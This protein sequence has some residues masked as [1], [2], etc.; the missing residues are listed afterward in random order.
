MAGL[1]VSRLPHVVVLCL[2]LSPSCVFGVDLFSGLLTPDTPFDITQAPEAPDY[3]KSKNWAALPSKE[4]NA[5]IVPKGTTEQD[6]Q[7]SAAIDAFYIHPTSYLLGGNWNA[8]VDD[9]L[10]KV[11]TDYGMLPQHA[12]VYNGV[13]RV[14]APR[15]RQASQGAQVNPLSLNDREQALALAF[16]DVRRAF[17]YFL[18][19]YNDGRPFLITS[20]SQGTTHAIPLLQYLFQERPKDARRL[21]AGYLI[22]NTVDEKWLSHLLPVCQT[23]TDTGCYLSWNAIAEGGDDSH[24]KSKG[25]PVCVNPLSWRQDNTAVPKSENLGSLPITGPYFLDAPHKA[26]TGARCEDGILWIT[27]PQ[28]R[29]YSMALFPGG[30]Y[31]A[32]DYNL[33]WMNIREN[34]RERTRAYFQQ[35]R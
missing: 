15:Y 23:G 32:Y 24:W 25:H 3:S 9:L 4:D 6:L 22:G 13:A 5:D 27:A 35:Q 20:H 8:S 12:A 29:G 31:H 30:G 1:R 34:L 7:A 33:F 19:Q 17:E 14:F 16:S 11:I 21:V 2:C 28:A 18:D 26:Q 10:S